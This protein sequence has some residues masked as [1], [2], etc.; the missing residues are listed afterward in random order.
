M[1]TKK[2]YGP[3]GAS[4]SDQR[5]QI[6]IP[7]DNGDVLGQVTYYFIYANEYDEPI[8]FKNQKCFSFYVS[9]LY[10]KSQQFQ[11]NE[12][13]FSQKSQVPSSVGQLLP[14][15]LAFKLLCDLNLT[16]AYI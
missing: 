9:S 13:D 1:T 4:D 3:F 14:M 7:I 8:S 12:I 2:K 10:Q 11:V 15:S 6:S 5:K 16:E